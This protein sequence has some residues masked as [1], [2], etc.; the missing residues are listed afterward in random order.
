MSTLKIYDLIKENSLVED[1]NVRGRIHKQYEGDGTAVTIWKKKQ[2]LVSC[3]IYSS[4]FVR[5][6]FCLYIYIYI[7]I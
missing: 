1:L 7:Y 5:I 4:I 2:V 6:N 3:V